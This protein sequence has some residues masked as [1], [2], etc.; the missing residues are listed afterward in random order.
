MVFGKIKRWWDETQEKQEQRRREEAEFR[1]RRRR[2][3]AEAKERARQA[4]EE[5]RRQRLEQQQGIMAEVREGRV[6]N[7][8][9]NVSMPFNLQKNESILYAAT[10][11][12]YAEMKIRREVVGRTRASRV[13]VMKGVSFTVPG[14]P[15]ERVESNEI[16]SRGT[17]LFAISTKHIHFDGGRTFRIRLDKIVAAQRAQGGIEVVRDR[18]S[19]LP[20]YFGVQEDD[21]GFVLDLIH[22]VPETDFQ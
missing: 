5:Q 6:P 21:I 18:A 3:E 20:E 17:G 4:A 10:P 7:L 2:E 16:V 11:I 22:T 1:E 19:G 9:F 13:R 15:G 8:Q 14:N 12:E